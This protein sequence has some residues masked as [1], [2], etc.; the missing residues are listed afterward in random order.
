MNAQWAYGYGCVILRNS[1]VIH[2]AARRVR[3]IREIPAKNINDAFLAHAVSTT[4]EAVG[5]DGARCLKPGQLI[6][7]LRR[8]PSVGR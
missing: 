2:V 3:L 6:A 7:T 1:H 8:R 4:D 5:G